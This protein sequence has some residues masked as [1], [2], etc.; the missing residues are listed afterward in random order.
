MTS[1]EWRRDTR[2]VLLDVG[3]VLTLPDPA[4]MGELLA[5][6][7]CVVDTQ[8]LARA[9]YVATAATDDAGGPDWDLY[10]RTYVR[11]CGVSAAMERNVADALGKVF[12]A[13]TWTSPIPDAAVTLRWLAESMMSLGIISNAAGNVAAILTE[14][15]L[16]QVGAGNLVSVGVIVDSHHVGV[17]K[18]DPRIF[19]FALSELGVAAEHA[20]YVGDTVYSDVVGATNAGIWPIH[21][22]PFGNC[23]RRLRRSHDHISGLRDGLDRVPSHGEHEGQGPDA[24]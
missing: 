15:G 22:D 5:I 8:K 24:E 7:G 23:P 21:M 12:T 20:I 17:E 4:V 18:P 6:Y 1:P 3:G 16:C 19:T 11:Y 9:H 13:D 14:A 10:R 2:A